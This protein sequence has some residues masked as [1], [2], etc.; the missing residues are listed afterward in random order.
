MNSNHNN[1]TF[2]NHNANN[3]Y[4]QDVVLSLSREVITFTIYISLTVLQSGGLSTYDRGKIS[5]FVPEVINEVII[6]QLTIC[7]NYDHMPTTLQNKTLHTK[8]YWKV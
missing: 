4:Y 2:I 5:V 8:G 6:K 7:Q 3:C 1:N